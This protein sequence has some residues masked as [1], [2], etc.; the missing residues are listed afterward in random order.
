MLLLEN[1]GNSNKTCDLKQFQ[2]KMTTT[3]LS[4][5]KICNGTWPFQHENLILN[6]KHFSRSQETYTL[7]KHE[8][9][10]VETFCFQTTVVKNTTKHTK[11]CQ[12][13]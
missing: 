7:N 10:S 6:R 1:D 3:K 9:V 2:T 11:Q 8:L 5:H 4:L 12:F 13:K